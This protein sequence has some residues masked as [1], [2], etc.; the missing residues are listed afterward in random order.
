MSGSNEGPT[1]RSG[2]YHKENRQAGQERKYEQNNE[3]SS[4]HKMFPKPLAQAL[5]PYRAHAPSFFG[6]LSLGLR[7]ESN[8]D[9][10]PS[11]EQNVPE[12]H[13]VGISKCSKWPVGFLLYGS[14]ASD[15]C[16]SA[17]KS[18]EQQYGV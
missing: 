16:L 3:Y 14:D 6:I 8:D 11:G 1:L 18:P 4:Q 10:S 5:T 13:S 2:S 9:S 7:H 15:H 12:R 17:S